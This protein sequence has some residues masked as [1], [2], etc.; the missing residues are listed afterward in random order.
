MGVV[1]AGNVLGLLDATTGV[2][3]QG[4]DQD[5]YQHAKS[6]NGASGKITGR[7]LESCWEGNTVD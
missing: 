6:L 5:A 1:L 4:L 3:D 7:N 2:E